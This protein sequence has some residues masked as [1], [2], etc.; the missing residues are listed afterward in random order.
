MALSITR[1]IGRS[2]RRWCAP[3]GGAF[4]KRARWHT[5]KG[6][7]PDAPWFDMGGAVLAYA[8]SRHPPVNGRCGTAGEMRITWLMPSLQQRVACEWAQ[9]RPARRHRNGRYEHQTTLHK[10]RRWHHIQSASHGP[11]RGDENLTKA[12]RQGFLSLT[13]VFDKLALWR[14]VAARLVSGPALGSASDVLNRLDPLH[15]PCVQ[16]AFSVGPLRSS[17]RWRGAQPPDWR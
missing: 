4:H 15:A 5:K 8:R 12:R 9:P 10:R 11:G 7:R 1:S 17:P 16:A 2:R 6:S 3:R 13:R 14:L